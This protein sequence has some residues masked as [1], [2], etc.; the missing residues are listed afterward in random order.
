MS[1]EEQIVH[2]Q[3]VGPDAVGPIFR[4]GEIAEAAIGAIA[5]DNPG[6]KV[7]V[8][9]RG[10]YIRVHTEHNCVLRRATME[11][12]LGRDYELCRLEI[13]MPSFAGRIRTSVNEYSWYHGGA[14]A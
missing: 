9:D 1:S 10:D 3:D 8:V 2:A 11:K 7:F 13:E 4:S 6:T 5:E 12:H 14:A